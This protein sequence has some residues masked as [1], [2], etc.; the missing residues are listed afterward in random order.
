M[1]QYFARS[2]FVRRFRRFMQ[3]IQHEKSVGSD[4][5]MDRKKRDV[6]W[7][8]DDGDRLGPSVRAALGILLESGDWSWW[9]DPSKTKKCLEAAVP[10]YQHARWGGDSSVLDADQWVD[11]FRAFKLGQAFDALDRNGRPKIKLLRSV[12]EWPGGADTV[13]EI[14]LELS[15]LVGPGRVFPEWKENVRPR[16]PE[17]NSQQNLGVITSPNPLSSEFISNTLEYVEWVPDAIV[18]D[19]VVADSSDILEVTGAAKLVILYGQSAVTEFTYVSRLRY[20][21]CAQ[22]VIYVEADQ[23]GAESWLQTLIALS[24]ERWLSLSESIEVAQ[25]RSAPT[26]VV[27]SSTQSFFSRRHPFYYSPPKDESY[28]VDDTSGTVLIRNSPPNRDSDFS[29]P[30]SI[31]FDLSV[32]NTQEAESEP[33]SEEAPSSA[34]RTF[35][36]DPPRPNRREPP[37]VQISDSSFRPERPTFVRPAPPVERVLNAQTWQGTKEVRVWPKEGSL[38]IKID[39]RVKSPL[40]NSQP[41]FPDDRVEWNE[42][43]RFLQVHLFEFGREPQREIISLSRTDN[44]TSATFNRESGAGSVDLRFLVSDGAQILQTARYQTAPGEAIRFFVEN[45]VTPVHRSKKAFDAA[46]LVNESLGSQ[47]SLTI[48]TGDGKAIFSPLS[49][50]D[51]GRARSQLLQDLEQAVVNPDTSLETLMLTLANQGALLQRHL[52]SIVPEWPRSDARIQL[53]T[54]S[55]AFFPIE[56]LYDGKVPESTKAPL[57]AQREGCLRKGSAI[58]NCH[59]REAAEELCPMGFLGVSGLIER[60]AWRAG[61]DPRIWG[62]PGGHKATRYR[63]GDLS[64]VAFTASDR[65][66]KF[67]DKNVLPHQAIR[68]AGIETSL[69]VKKITDWKNWKERIALDSP[70]MLLMVLHLDENKV[71]VGEDDGINL[72]S[73][74]EQ[75]IGNAPMVIA[76]GC[77]SGLAD[78]PGGSL[79]AI[80]Q[81]SG[82]RVVIA[83]MTNVLGRHANRV[84]RDLAI[85]LKAAAR[86]PTSSS[87][88]EVVSCI[89][90]ELLADGLALG[91]AVVAFG[92]ADIVLGQG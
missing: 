44:S 59:I 85:R 49:D 41:S 8:G 62:A 27:L 64:T 92:D 5:E 88:G 30:D 26:T 52:Q 2:S 67:S 15:R 21:L 19:I 68:I 54:Q 7:L 46:L 36:G 32:N 34:E 72:A 87:V 89:R 48:I 78:I 1:R 91:L 70:S 50:T 51:A 66:D 75:H 37:A 65:A 74:G 56:Y 76:I 14:A 69:G 90:R 71:F 4:W 6:Q 55:D 18:A 81:R 38:K 60:H 12:W 42:D 73:I 53:V 47:P 24:A 45:I 43:R 63:I 28:R 25:T 16:F 35:G 77:S 3:L 20:E 83:A 13:G 58:L 31:S 10:R 23:N 33:S 17:S 84:G 82:A 57:C 79:P 9:D 22:C 40:Q 86:A 11:P 39:I 29:L 80:L 61:Q